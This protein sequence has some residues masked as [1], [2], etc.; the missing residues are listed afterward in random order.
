MWVEGGGDG[1]DDLDWWGSE[2]QRG[3]GDGRRAVWSEEKGDD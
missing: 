2:E 1:E 3:E